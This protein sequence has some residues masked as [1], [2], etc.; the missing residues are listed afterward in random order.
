MH[1]GP[2]ILDLELLILWKCA[3]VQNW[4]HP[5]TAV[6]N[7]LSFLDTTEPLTLNHTCYVIMKRVQESTITFPNLCS[8]RC[9]GSWIFL[10]FSM[11]VIETYCCVKHSL[12]H[13]DTSEKHGLGKYYASSKDFSRDDDTMNASIGL[14]SSWTFFKNW[15][16][17]VGC[18]YCTCRRL[19]V[20]KAW[21]EEHSYDGIQANWWPVSPGVLFRALKL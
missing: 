8:S 3:S 5:A 20:K 7:P 15:L 12:D 1:L 2:I 10:C 6:S 19:G 17:T 11:T 13:E 16:Q 21:V 9:Q 18:M 14:Q 4:S